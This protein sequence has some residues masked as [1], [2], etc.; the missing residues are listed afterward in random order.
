M[1]YAAIATALRQINFQGD[2]IIE[3]AHERRLKAHS[4]LARELEDEPRV[5][6]AGVWVLKPPST[7][8]FL[9]RCLSKG[10]TSGNC[11]YLLLA[12]AEFWLRSP[13]RQLWSSVKGLPW[14]HRRRSDLIS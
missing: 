11:S 10:R 1:D 12:K 8:P 5:C 7:Q 9:R 13:L 4:T 2:A 3:L 14:K 6:A